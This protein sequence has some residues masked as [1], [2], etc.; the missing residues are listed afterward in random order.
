MS[1]G[2]IIFVYLFFVFVSLP[3]HSKQTSSGA[4]QRRLAAN[5]FEVIEAHVRSSIK[6]DSGSK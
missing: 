3:A 1:C 2:V 6:F 4:K 5:Q